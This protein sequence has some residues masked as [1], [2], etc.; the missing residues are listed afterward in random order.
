MSRR[1][2]LLAAAA[3]LGA[4]AIGLFALRSRAPAVPPPAVA[5]PA[6]AS[7]GTNVVVVI[8]CTFRADQTTPYGGPAHTTPFLAEIAARGTRFDTTI[9]QAPWTRPGI[10]AILTSRHPLAID[11]AHPGRGFDPS[12]VH[13]AVTTLAERFQAAGHATVG[14]TANPNG[15]SVFGFD[16]GFD[17]YFEPLDLWRRKTT[18]VG[19]EVLVED[20]L[21]HLPEDGRPLY[22]QL[23]LVDAHAPFGR[24][25]WER[26]VDGAPTKRVG[27][28]RAALSRLDGSIGALWTALHERGYDESNTVFVVVGDHGEGLDHP[29]HHGHGHGHY[30]Y[31][32]AVHVPWLMMGPG[33]ARGHVVEGLSAQVDVVPT[34]LGLLGLPADEGTAGRDLSALVAGEGHE[35]NT[36]RVFVDTWFRSA[37]RAAVYTNDRFCQRDFAR[38]ASAQRERAAARRGKGTPPPFADGCWDWRTDREATRLVED[39]ELSAQ[40]ELWR[41]D[42]LAEGDA[43]RAEHPREEAAPDDEIREALERLGYVE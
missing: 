36:E 23:L 19:G 5:T 15:N 6:R 21:A 25:G 10:T 13:S 20:A 9:A 22:L 33:V 4:V 39:T 42:R 14:G 3:L 43:F 31:P 27:K 8:G 29:E 41:Q 17:H 40:L 11:M 1:T 37:S 28:Y 35:T 12:R 24:R 7:V 18:K 26:F 2:A 32:S 34:L 30:L 16:Q 38:T